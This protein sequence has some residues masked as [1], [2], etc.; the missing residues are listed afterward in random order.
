MTAPSSGMK[1]FGAGALL[2]AALFWGGAFAAQ[3][4][5]S[6]HIG[7]FGFIAG[8]SIVASLFL[9]ALIAGRFLATKLTH[10]A[11][12]KT[13]PSLKRDYR[14]LIIG[15]I[16]CGV[17]LFVADNFQ[18]AGISAYPPEAAASG[19]SGFITATYVVMVAIFAFFAGKKI[20]PL[21][22]CSLVVC[23]LGMYMLCVRGGLS[24][25]YLGDVLVLASALFYAIH[26]VA[27]G[28][29]SLLDALWLS[30]IQFITNATMSLICAIVIEHITPA[31]FLP[32]LLP[33]VYVGIF[34]TGLGY[35]L[36]TVGQKY[37]DAAPAAIIMSLESVFAAL[38]GWVVLGEVL[39]SVELVGCAL[40]FAA[41]IMA[42]CPEF[43]KPR[44]KP[45]RNSD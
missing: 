20:H 35:T 38:S 37:V 5:A 33:I 34:S 6:D 14:I 31:S 42:Q 40:V 19:R 1:L 39:S 3:S 7:S 13:E 26:I 18:Q 12:S 28:R 10:K 25:I 4:M 32:A 22:V 8:K 41:V 24:G 43:M 21:V 17:A 16:I 9:G 2:C 44:P 29:F 45:R 23:L 30:L 27:V 36:Q 11:N 15:G